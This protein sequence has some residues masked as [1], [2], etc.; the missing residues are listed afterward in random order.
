V[1]QIDPEDVPSTAALS[2]LLWT[3]LSQSNFGDFLRT[4]HAKLLPS[5]Q[6][7]EYQNRYQDTGQD[8][9]LLEEFERELE[10]ERTEEEK[11]FRAW[12]RG[13][14]QEAAEAAKAGVPIGN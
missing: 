7:L 13:R 12:K 8:L 4:N 9:A 10:A 3:Q 6:E 11:L 14:E 1:K 2:I 5:K